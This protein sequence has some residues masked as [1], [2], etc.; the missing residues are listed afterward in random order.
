[1]GLSRKIAQLLDTSFG[2]SFLHLSASEGREILTKIL[3]NTPY[4][5]ICDDPLEDI[6][7]IAPKEEPMIVEPEPLA[8]PLESSTILQVPEPPKEEEIPLSKDMFE[9][10]EDLFSNFG[11]TLNYSAIRKS[12]APSAPNQHLFDPTEDKFL[13]N[14]VKELTTIISNDW[15]SESE[16]SHE[17]IRLDSPST[18]ISCQ[19]H[20]TSF[21]ALDNPVVGVNIMSKYFA[22]TLFEDI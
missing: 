4:T 11:N 13:K 7:E 12:L 16:L 10:E 3:E 14:T 6:V 18:S 9:F 17:V 1:V 15:L 22:H 8:T 2:G 20:Q 21:D 19:I 5:S